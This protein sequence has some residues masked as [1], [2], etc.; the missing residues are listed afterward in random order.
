MAITP[1]ATSV[2]NITQNR[3]DVLTRV[4][5][6][7]TGFIDGSFQAKNTSLCRKNLLIFSFLLTNLTTAIS[8]EDENNTVYYSTRL[9][10]YMHPCLYHCYFAEK[11]TEATYNQYLTINSEEDIYYNALYKTGQMVN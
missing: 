1:T 6:A 9:L 4:I 8:K 10:K 3:T 11:E 7:A 5:S 2:T